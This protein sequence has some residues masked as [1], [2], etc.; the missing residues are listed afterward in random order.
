MAGRQRADLSKGEEDHF[1][2]GSGCEYP[3]IRIQIMSAS[4]SQWKSWV[5]A[6]KN[7]TVERI[8]GLGEEAYIRNNK[9]LFAEL[10]AKVGSHVISLQKNLG[11][12]ETMQA[13]KPQLI[14]LAKAVAGMLQ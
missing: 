14:A 11:T 7:P 12:D 9:N 2:N 4:A 13:T 5:D 3:V 6:S 10:Y 1:A 8:A